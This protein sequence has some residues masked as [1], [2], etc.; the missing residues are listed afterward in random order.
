MPARA[1]GTGLLVQD[2]GPVL[3]ALGDI[4]GNV[5]LPVLLHA[6]VVVQIELVVDDLRSVEPS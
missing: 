1:L 5:L 4:A 3:V 6:G 2:A